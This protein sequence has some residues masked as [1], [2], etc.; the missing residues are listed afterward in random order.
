MA[1]SGSE[2]LAVLC[3]EDVEPRRGYVGTLIEGS[4]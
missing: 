2:W 3:G 1:Y 4:N